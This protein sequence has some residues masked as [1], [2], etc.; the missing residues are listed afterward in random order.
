YEMSLGTRLNGFLMSA[1]FVPANFF[2]PGAAVSET[3]S[4]FVSMFLHGGWMHLLGNML[5]LWIFGDN[6]EDRLGRIKYLLFYLLCGVPATLGHG[7][8]G[9]NSGV[10]SVGASGAI[11]G[12]LGAYLLTFPQARVL[13]LV[14][15]G[16]YTQIRELPAIMVLGFWFVLQFFSGIMSLGARNVGGVAWWAHIGGCVGGR[17]VLQRRDGGPPPSAGEGLWGPRGAVA[18]RPRPLPRR[19]RPARL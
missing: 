10:P 17:G 7:L 4:I 16:F 12:V 9:R 1:A 3:R 8:S 13:T 14:P 15:L 19:A 2:Q 6:I 18:R 5:Y 11:A